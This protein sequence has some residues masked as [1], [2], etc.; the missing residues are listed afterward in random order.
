MTAEQ[1]LERSVLES[2][3]RDELH[4]IAQAMALKTT[5][6]TKKADIIDR[7]LE[8]TGVTAPGDQAATPSGVADG[9]GA[10][11]AARR[12][13][14]AASA[15]SADGTEP[16]T[17]GE[18]SRPT[19]PSGDGDGPTPATNDTATDAAPVTSGPSA[20][21]GPTAA[22]RPTAA[23][24]ETSGANGA[25]SNGHGSADATPG[26]TTFSASGSAD[27]RRDQPSNGRQDRGS[28]RQPG[29][30]QQN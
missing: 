1:Q 14:T 19:G 24:T 29:P 2:K 6:R 13:R 21:R 8:A 15:P 4:A 17:D 23:S 28:G 3:E 9:N 25:S 16:V 22:D 30:G 27:N 26:A 7:I 11:P 20:D 10:R 12:G 5:T 18:T